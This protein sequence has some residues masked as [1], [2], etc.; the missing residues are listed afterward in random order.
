M[1]HKKLIIIAAA[2]VLGSA[3]L[4]MF[5]GPKPGIREGLI[6]VEG[7][8]YTADDELTCQAESPECGICYGEIIN[9]EC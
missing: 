6:K 8:R 5:N 3:V 4:L 7:Y 9:K 2:V 1:K